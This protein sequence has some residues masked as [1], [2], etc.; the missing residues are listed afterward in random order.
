MHYDARLGVPF[1]ISTRGSAKTSLKNGLRPGIHGTFSGP[2]EV[3]FDVPGFVGRETAM[4][5]VTLPTTGSWRYRIS[6]DEGA[7]LEE[8]SIEC[9]PGTDLFGGGLAIDPNNSQRF[10][11]KDGRPVFLLSYESDWLWALEAA[12]PKENRIASFL[13]RIKEAGF[14]A[15]MMNC[16]AHDTTWSPGNRTAR[17]FGPPPLFPWG[18]TNDSPDFDTLNHDF[19]E[20]MDRVVEQFWRE[21][22]FLHLFFK[23]YNKSVNW[24]DPDSPADEAYFHHIVARYQAY[25][26]MIWDFAKETYYEIDKSYVR[27]RMEQIGQWDAHNRLRTVHD[28]L[29]IYNDPDAETFLEFQTVQ[30]HHDFHSSVVLEHRN[31]QWPYVNSEFGYECG[32]GGTTDVT[33]GVGQTP[34]EL[35]RRAY[36]VAC[37]GGYPAYYYSY[38]AWDIIHE[39]DTPPG[40]RFFRILADFFGALDYASFAPAPELC[41]WRSSF[42][43]AKGDPSNPGEAVFFI[44]FHVLTPQQLSPERYTGEWLNIYTGERQRLD[45]ESSSQCVDRREYTIYTIPFST[46]FAV[47]H[48]TRRAGAADVAHPNL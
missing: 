19:W 37:S 41:L 32:P 12:Y 7:L 30:Q 24:P 34:Q 5:R 8:G 22:V 18:G 15:V 38:T 23:V 17:D 28:D 9:S 11:L 26:C 21:G 45:E 47:L 20:C 6:L 13:R 44:D 42:C 27:R 36:V 39:G 2:R 43:L 29:A 1:E 31:H 25:S 4:V 35:I 10:I 33:Y 14:N 16:Y 3:A 40:Y 48:L 46:P